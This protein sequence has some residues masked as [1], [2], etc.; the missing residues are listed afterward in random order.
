MTLPERQAWLRLVLTPGLT[1]SVARHLLTAFGL[2]TALFE[3]V[4]ASQLLAVC[5]DPAL[6]AVLRAPPDSMV[7]QAMQAAQLWLDQ[8]PNGFLVTLADPDYP[9]GLFDLTDPPL[10]LFGLGRR[11]LLGQTAIALVGSR[12]ATRLG[13]Q[14]AHDFARTLAQAGWCIIS[15]LATGIDAHAHEGALHANGQTLAVLGTGIDL[16]YPIRNVDLYQRLATNG[17]LLSEYPPGTPPRP[18]QFPRRN[19]LIAALSKGVVVVEAAIRS[20]SLITA[21]LANDMGREIF[22][23]PGSIHSPLARGCHRLIREGAKLVESAQDIL[24]ELRVTP[25][26][27][28]SKVTR[29]EPCIAAGSA[30]QASILRAMGHD[31]ISFDLLAA[32][33]HLEPGTLAAALLELEF[34]GQIERLPGQRF[35][36]LPA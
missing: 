2:P 17:L 4:S 11:T 28:A 22:A 7:A 24:V 10:V 8:H 6:V 5:G 20:G 18:H 3:G 33:L 21:R 31:P 32:G 29:P 13:G 9:S 16:P 26:G 12:H 1:P 19:R 30:V 36:V 15:G 23:I 34:L 35:Q 14:T 25:G 27:L